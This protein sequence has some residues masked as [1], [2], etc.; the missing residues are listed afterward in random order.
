MAAADS[1]R[2]RVQFT[3]RAFFILTPLIGLIAILTRWIIQL[4]ADPAI[5]TSIA[6]GGLIGLIC[7]VILQNLERTPLMSL[8]LAGLTISAICYAGY[9]L[10]FLAGLIGGGVLANYGVAMLNFLFRVL[11][12]TVSVVELQVNQEESSVKPDELRNAQKKAADP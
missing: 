2:E 10:H 6:L 4:K 5:L 12:L 3:T 11:G 8:L 1:R 9:Y 7:V